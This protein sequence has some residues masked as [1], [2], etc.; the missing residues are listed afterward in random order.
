MLAYVS[1]NG[2]LRD[3]A[4]NGGEN[5]DLHK[6]VHGIPGSKGALLRRNKSF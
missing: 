4:Q 1:S 6:L 3:G 2:D 5:G